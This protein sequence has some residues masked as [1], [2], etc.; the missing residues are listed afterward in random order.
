MDCSESVHQTVLIEVPVNSTGFL[1]CYI[2]TICRACLRS[3]P[4]TTFPLLFFQVLKYTQTLTS[5]RSLTMTNIVQVSCSNP[6]CN[7]L[8]PMTT[9]QKRKF[10]SVYYVKY[11]QVVL[12]YC[13]KDC[14]KKHMEELQGARTQVKC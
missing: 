7:N 12:P 3:R 5:T 14:Q 8:I 1:F 11:G 13:C 4:W 9:T 6:D 10:F 2:R